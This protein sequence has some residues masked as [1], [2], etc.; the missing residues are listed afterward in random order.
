VAIKLTGINYESNDD[1]NELE[2]TSI[3][4]APDLKF[5]GSLNFTKN[6]PAAGETIDIRAFV[7][8]SGGNADDVTL[9]FY[10]GTT[11][12]GR[13]T[14]DVDYGDTVTISLSWKVPDK[15]G[16]TLTIKA[17]VSMKDGPEREGSITVQEET[18]GFA[19]LDSP[20]GQTGMMIGLGIAIVLLIVGLLVGM[21]M[22]KKRGA[23]AGGAPAKGA[24]G[25][26]AGQAGPAAPAAAPPAFKAAG[27]K[28]EGGKEAPKG[29]ISFEKTGAE[30][31]P[32]PAT[33]QIARVRCPKC[34]KTTDVTSTQRPLQIPC[35]CGT[36]LMLKK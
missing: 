23:A 11:E 5:E 2:F 24:P 3:D 29:P 17:E 22:G 18:G 28:P 16:E 15:A 25:A 21:M 13:E 14:K 33:K 26:P 19:A 10:E 36:T 7:S 27:A 32:K 8:N 9:I 12:I 4:L 34:G 1:N 31:K 30:D 20:A 35:S 6:N